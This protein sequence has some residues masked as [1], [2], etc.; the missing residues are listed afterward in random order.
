MT[1]AAAKKLHALLDAF[2]RTHE[3]HEYMR[4]H[5]M[6]SEEHA[7]EVEHGR[8]FAALVAFVRRIEQAA[9]R[10]GYNRCN[11]VSMR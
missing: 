11:N 4:G 5:G 9:D 8:S 6:P 7:A 1:P 3:Q 2:A 10:R